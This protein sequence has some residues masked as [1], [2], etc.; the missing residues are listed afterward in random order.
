VV[1]N[2]TTMIDDAELLRRYAEQHSDAAFAE[3]VQ[4]H[5]GLVYAAALRQL[6]GATHRAEDVTQGVF[7]DLARKA[8]SLSRHRQ[9]AGWLYTSTHYAAAKLK[10]TEQ[11]RQQREQEASAMHETNASSGLPADWEQLRPVLDD[12]MH[13]LTESDREAILLRFFQGRSFSEVGEQCGITADAARMRTERSLD[14]LRVLLARREI[15]STTSALGLL[16]ANQPVVAV[17]ATLAATVTG[18]ALASAVG[19]G[20]ATL[21]FMNSKAIVT[22]I[23]AAM[24]VGFGVYEYHDARTARAGTAALVLERDALHAR[25][26]E[27]EQRVE[28]ADE[29]IS[30]IQQQMQATRT[31][32]DATAF[33]LPPPK[34]EAVQTASAGEGGYTFRATTAAQARALNAQNVDATYAALYRQLN[35]TPAQ[36]EQFRN[37]MLDR[38]ESGE[39]LFKSAVAAARAKDPRIGRAEMHE[40]FEATNAQTHLEQQAELRRVWGDA[41]GQALQ[42]Y[43]ATL[44]IR[45]IANQLASALFNSASPITPVQSDQ[46]VN[47][48]AQHARGPVGKIEAA[49]L[50]IEAAAAQVQSQGLLNAT[51]L[52]ELRRVMLRVQEQSK[53]ERERMAAPTTAAKTPGS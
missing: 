38:Q 9:L 36:R 39:R 1:C 47:I 25:V 43:Q 28:L 49:A 8:P 20:A 23:G 24:A 27:M 22:T 6:H 15:T 3:L 11:R 18:A 33:A 26:R 52:D 40:V 17:P 32:K 14:K 45:G 10:R 48:L 51:Q 2:D 4:R 30:E 44:P 50:D 35:L 7:I 21:L 53:S 29:R 19:G 31:M 12:A 41:A 46:V 34:T 16:L 5:I 13:K 42:Q 37:L